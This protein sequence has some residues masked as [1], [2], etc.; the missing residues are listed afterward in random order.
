MRVGHRR[1]AAVRF[2]H[3]RTSRLPRVAG[4][5]CLARALPLAIAWSRS[6]IAG[7]VGSSSGRPGDL[8]I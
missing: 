3:G 5:A 6:V 7:S 2:R 8:A 4:A 1:V